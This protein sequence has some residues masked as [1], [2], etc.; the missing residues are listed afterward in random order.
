MLNFQYWTLAITHLRCKK[1]DDGNLSVLLD[2]YYSIFNTAEFSL[3]SRY[4]F[5]LLHI[6]S[7]ILRGCFSGRLFPFEVVSWLSVELSKLECISL[8]TLLDPRD[9]W[10]IDDDEQPLLTPTH[11]MLLM[12]IMVDSKS[13]SKR[14]RSK[15]KRMRTIVKNLSV[16][17]CFSI[18]DHVVE[19]DKFSDGGVNENFYKVLS[20]SGATA[21]NQSLFKIKF[22]QLADMMGVL[23]GSSNVLTAKDDDKHLIQMVDSCPQCLSSNNT[24]NTTVQHMCREI[25]HSSGAT[26]VIASSL[27]ER[28]FDME[29]FHEQVVS[30]TDLTLPIGNDKYFFYSLTKQN[31]ESGKSMNTL[32]TESLMALSNMLDDCKHKRD[33][34]RPASENIQMSKLRM[35]LSRFKNPLKRTNNEKGEVKLLNH[36]KILLGLGGK[37][38]TSKV[39]TELYT[40]D[41][42]DI[43]S[44]VSYI[45]RSRD[46]KLFT[47]PVHKILTKSTLYK[48]QNYFASNQRF[49]VDKKNTQ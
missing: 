1:L 33:D 49:S 35:C 45:D 14:V 22:L 29:S 37:W 46:Y 4:D 2:L 44:K 7:C 40:V 8:T 21:T 39:Y 5:S 18:V 34:F 11:N 9:S 48:L 31:M 42:M 19:K 36:S 6:S 23:D 12:L 27:F 13:I 17:D 30:C 15:H 38:I 16:E 43:K 47:R 32:R 10:V 25:A 24:L 3:Q 41:L 26:T 28:E 20:K